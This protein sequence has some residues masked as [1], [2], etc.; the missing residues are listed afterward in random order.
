VEGST[1]ITTG[2]VMPADSL[3]ATND[4]TGLNTNLV[5]SSEFVRVKRSN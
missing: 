5:D 2:W 3:L 1:V 4:T